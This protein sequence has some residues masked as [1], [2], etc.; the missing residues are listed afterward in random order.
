MK[1]FDFNTIENFDDHI[2]KSIPNY[3]YLIENIIGLSDYF[4]EKESIVYDLGC[5]TGKLLRQ[6]S[7]ETK[8]IGIDIAEL[9]P[10]ENDKGNNIE[11]K[12]QDLNKNFKISNASIVYSIFTMQF[13][14]RPCRKDYIK[15]IYDGLNTGA[16][17][18][19]CEKIYQKE[20][21]FQEIIAFTHYDYKCRNFSEKEI[22]AK[23]RDLRY[24]MKPDTLEE[25]ISMLKAAGFTKITQFW[26][27]YNFIGL[28]A[29]K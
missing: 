26:Q 3:N 18:I 6:L 12:N 14:K 23:E 17:L 15:N 27:S 2:D 16:A 7:K 20:G 9:L 22:I 24:I 28:I 4:L 29:I 8:K 19:L 5:S 11:Y 13:L 10:K 21:L 1:K 25:N